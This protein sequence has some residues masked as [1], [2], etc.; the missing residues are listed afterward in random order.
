MNEQNMRIRYLFHSG[1]SV[2]TGDL[3]LVF[4]YYQ[5]P[6][7]LGPKKVVFFASHSH[8]DHYN[9]VILH[10]PSD[11]PYTKYILSSDIK[12][13]S[14]LFSPKI[15]LVSPGQEVAVDG[16]AIKVFGS[17]D[18]G[19][20]FLVRG[21]RFSLFHAGDLNWWAWPDDTEEEAQAAA[22][23]FREEIA[24]LQNEPIDLAFFP[25]DPRLDKHA[26]WGAEYFIRHIRPRYFVPMHFSGQAAVLPKYISRL[27]GLGSQIIV[28]TKKGEHTILPFACQQPPT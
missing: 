22:R 26:S 19:V 17:T 1:F 15:I 10:D 24:R 5:G 27:E 16:L 23:N 25:V 9:P 14:A 28:L 6:L 21:D 3:M 4:D 7:E 12:P 11:N 2:E 8:R 13:P 20:S 18:Q